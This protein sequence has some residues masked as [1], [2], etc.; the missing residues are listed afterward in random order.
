MYTVTF[1]S[2]NERTLDGSQNYVQKFRIEEN[3]G[4]LVLESKVL[5]HNQFEVG[6]NKYLL[7][8]ST[9]RQSTTIEYYPDAVL[10]LADFNG[11][12]NL[13]LYAV[14]KD[15]DWTGCTAFKLNITSNNAIVI[16]H[17]DKLATAKEIAIDFGD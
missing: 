15:I 13:D 4:K 9:K 6:N 1:Y 5:R 17:A 2:K 16:A 14:W 8:W 12:T 11:K 7:G 10:T 3:E